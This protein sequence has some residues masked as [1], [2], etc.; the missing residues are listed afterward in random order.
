[1]AR[2]FNGTSDYLI[3][4]TAVVTT[5]PLTMA[6]WA[7][8]DATGQATIMMRIG[9]NAATTG[10]LNS[11]G[12]R[13]NASDIVI[14]ST[15][16]TT[17]TGASSASS[18]I[19]ANTWYH[20]AGVYTS[21]TSRQLY[22][23]GAAQTANPTSLTPSGLDDTKIGAATYTSGVITYMNGQIADAGI[24][25]VVLTA[26]EIESLSKGIPPSFIRPESLVAYWP[27]YGR[28]SPEIDIHNRYEMTLTGTS[29]ADH[30]RIYMP[31]TTYYPYSVPV[32]NYFKPPSG[33]ALLGVGT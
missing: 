27:L 22:I 7:K 23:N 15:A 11:F 20:C 5:T 14:A 30:P 33:L 6:C 16:N 12:L 26:A 21:A 13:K 8:W 24:W 25:N 1:M 32:V 4:N 17:T 2:S 19:V 31:T 29:A 10:L 18:A 9:D 28:A 3:Y